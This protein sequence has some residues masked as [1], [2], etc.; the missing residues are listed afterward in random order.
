MDY[1]GIQAYFPITNKNNPSLRE[2][3]KGWKK[4]IELLEA[5]SKKHNKPILFSETGYRS[6]ETATI[7]PWVWGSA[8]D[9]ITNKKS[10]ET[11]NLAYE[12]LFQQLWDKDWFAGFILLAM[13][14]RFSRR[15]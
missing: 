11:Q 8:L 15:R 7:E 3:K 1:I 12:A 4:Q 10:F 9:V 14:C 2:I 6:D 13:A 5:L